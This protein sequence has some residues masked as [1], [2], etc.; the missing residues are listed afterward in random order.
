VTGAG[1]AA[2]LATLTGHG[3]VVRSV[4]F[5]PDGRT[6]ASAGDDRTVRLWDIDPNRVAAD[7]CRVASPVV[8]SEEWRRYFPDLPYHPPC[9]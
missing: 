7:V 5:S 4:A 1:H 8:T 6:L 2:P 3:D 9:R